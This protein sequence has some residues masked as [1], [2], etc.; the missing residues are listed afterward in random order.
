MHI[1]PSPTTSPLQLDQQEWPLSPRGCMQLLILSSVRQDWAIAG[2]RS[3][4]DVPRIRPYAPPCLAQI[5]AACCRRR[6][7]WEAD[8]LLGGRSSCRLAGP[9]PIFPAHLWRGRAICEWL[10]SLDRTESLPAWLVTCREMVE[11][12]KGS[13]TWSLPRPSASQW[14]RRRRLPA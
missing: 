12:D 13:G 11:G 6:A 5:T 10:A 8:N 14:C 7:C 9:D 4:S 3:C 1:E 2:A